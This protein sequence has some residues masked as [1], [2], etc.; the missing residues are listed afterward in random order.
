MPTGGRPEQGP[1]NIRV[2]EPTPAQPPCWH[3]ATRN[4]VADCAGRDAKRLGKLIGL[5]PE[6][7]IEG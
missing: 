1:R 2:D 4:P 7:V 3:L 5:N 6:A